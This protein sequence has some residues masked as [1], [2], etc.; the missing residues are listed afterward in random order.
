MADLHQIE[1]N[2]KQ[3]II[4]ADLDIQEYDIGHFPENRKPLAINVSVGSGSSKRVTMKKFKQDIKIRMILVFKH[5]KS[6]DE[7]KRREKTLPIVQAIE[8]LLIDGNLGLNIGDITPKGFA[9]KTAPEAFKM[10]YIVWELSFESYHYISKI[11]NVPIIP[12]ERIIANYYLQDPDNG[13]IDAT[14]FIN[15]EI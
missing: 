9:Y 6:G 7:E 14:D 11:S 15:F 5:L 8:G 4:D 10:G 3:K 13:E 1:I 2:T 12:L